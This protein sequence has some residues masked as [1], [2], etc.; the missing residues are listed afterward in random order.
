MRRLSFLAPG[1]CRALL[2]LCAA[3][4]PAAAH[5][6]ED[7]V[8]RFSPVNQY[9]INLTAAYW[10]PIMD[11]VSQKSG[12]KLQMKIGRTSADT[13]A[14]VLAQEVEFVFTN[15][16]FSPEREQ[17]GWKVFGRRVT[18]PVHGQIIVP[19]DSPLNDLAQLQGREVV[20]AGP[21]ALVA[22]KFPAAQLMARKID[23]KTV[24]GGNSDGSLAQLFSGKVA[25]AGV[26]SQLAEGYA[27][28]EGKKYRVLWSSPPLHDLALMV[29]SKVPEPV[30]SAVARAFIGMQRD[31]NG[32]GILQ[33][34]STQ[35]G[36]EGEASFI[37][38]D[39][40]EYGAFRD[41]YRSAPASMR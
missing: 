15:H 10:N 33:Q 1:L 37:A 40:S 5:A 38:S 26:N 2:T 21:E 31:P 25:A 4:A 11:Y 27:R 6:Q 17:L 20:F 32:R 41:F 28:R 16:L 39:G 12:V 3:I 8:Y 14:Y 34:A 7:G 29:S 9:G 18:P 19:A 24:F 30:R 36:L 23:F 22:Y 35:V 13:T